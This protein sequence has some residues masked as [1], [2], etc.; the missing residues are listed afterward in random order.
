MAKGRHGKKEE[1]SGAA[2][3]APDA[4]VTPKGLLQTQ[5]T[6]QY[7][8]MNRLT[9]PDFRRAAAAFQASQTKP[10]WKAL[11]SQFNGIGAALVDAGLLMPTWVAAYNGVPRFSGLTNKFR[12]SNDIEIP[13]SFA[14]ASLDGSVPSSNN[15]V[16]FITAKVTVDN[17]KGETVGNLLVVS[18]FGGNLN[19]AVRGT[20]L[21]NSSGPDTDGSRGGH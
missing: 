14:N 13:A 3:A 21:P 16:P 17:V 7:I 1:Q 6:L 19:F 2:A 20:I 8:I 9:S 18:S 15:A 10:T 5:G 11:N 12:N 4:L